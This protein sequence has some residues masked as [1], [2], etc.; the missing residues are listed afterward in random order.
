MASESQSPVSS[1]P[2]LF[3]AAIIPEMRPATMVEAACRTAGGTT[4]EF[5][6]MNFSLHRTSVVAD[7][8]PEAA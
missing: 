2:A 8:V 6:V 5:S 1:T 7:I 3:P 4:D